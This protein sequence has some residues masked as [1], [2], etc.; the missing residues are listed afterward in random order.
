MKK[1]SITALCILYTLLSY[2]VYADEAFDIPPVTTN[3]YQSSGLLFE[4]IPI[5]TMSRKEDLYQNFASALSL[6]DSGDAY[7]YIRQQCL[8]HAE[9]IYLNNY[10]I[11]VDDAANIYY[12][13]ATCNPDLLIG[14]RFSYAY[15]P[16]TGLIAYIK[17][18]YLFA[19]KEETAAALDKMNGI[20]DEYVQLASNY[21]D[22][23]RQLLS[24]HDEMT[25]RCT[26]DHN[27]SSGSGA[28]NDSFHAYG[29][30]ADGSAVCQGYAQAFFAIAREL[31]MEAGF[32]KSDAANHMWNYVKLGDSWYHIDVTYDDPDNADSTAYHH[33]FLV[34]DSTIINNGSH[35]EKPEWETYF[36]ALP[37]CSDNSYE[38]NFIFNIGAP[39]GITYSDSQYIINTTANGTDIT[40]RSDSL[41]TLGLL[42]SD[43]IRDDTSDMLIIA[44]TDNKPIELGIYS[45][46]YN[47]GRLL[48][49]SRTD[50][51]VSSKF[52]L[53][54]HR[55]INDSASGNETK[56]F[57]WSPQTQTPYAPAAAIK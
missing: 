14:T 11:S 47:N 35:S 46:L 5:E 25:K 27:T 36:D 53:Y 24:V 4:A 37:D 17:P 16:D 1:F 50:R 20:I 40:F 31:G 29:F 34:T 9:T 51:A 13:V 39:C 15:Y 12:S 6:Y 3:A 18:T 22:P 48:W 52:T 19:T 49:L 28:Y 33:N 32:C 57:F 41:K 54:G 23:L 42:V 8:E 43:V 44:L 45:A 30:F 38:R 26:Y 56:F 55:F 2:S 7:E 10:G 21:Q